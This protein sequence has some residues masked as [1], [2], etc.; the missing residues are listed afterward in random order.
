MTPENESLDNVPR[1]EVQGER[2]GKWGGGEGEGGGWRGDKNKEE[3]EYRTPKHV[4]QGYKNDDG[5]WSGSEGLDG[6]ILFTAM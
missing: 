1:R 4:V 3:R 6:A 2:R 5:D